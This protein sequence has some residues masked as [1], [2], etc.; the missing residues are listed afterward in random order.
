MH[1]C[2]DL[3][4]RIWD[5]VEAGELPGDLMNSIGECPKCVRELAF[6]R[7][8]ADGFEVLRSLDAPEVS[9]RQVAGKTSAGGWLRPV[10]AVGMAAVVLIAAMVVWNVDRTP[11]LMRTVKVVEQPEPVRAEKPVT[12]V[13]PPK[14]EEPVKV[15]YKAPEKVEPEPQPEVKRSQRNVRVYRRAER[16][17]RAERQA[18]RAEEWVSRVH[19][20]SPPVQYRVDESRGMEAV[21]VQGEGGYFM[22]TLPDV[23]VRR[24]AEPVGEREERAAWEARI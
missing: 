10:M 8:A 22:K 4:N 15:V 23:R 2:D 24:N 12:V 1:N 20:Q 6:A 21:V 14:R 11:E 5:A 3:R 16:V 9:Y 7:S 19:S 18:R 17:V 13:M